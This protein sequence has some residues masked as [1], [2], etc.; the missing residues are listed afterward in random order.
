MGR[1]LGPDDGAGPGFERGAPPRRSA[2]EDPST[3]APR[4]ASLAT[5]GPTGMRGRPL[6][7][8]EAGWVLRYAGVRARRA[9][10]AAPRLCHA[11]AA[12]SKRMFAQAPLVSPNA[13]SA[14][15][16]QGS[17]EPRRGTGASRP[18]GVGAERVPPGSPRPRGLGPGLSR[19][20]V[21]GPLAQP[22][23]SGRA[24]MEACGRT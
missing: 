15:R 20:C 14:P 23:S 16:P 12:T 7:L 21:D 5:V 11:S 1:G 17:V 3:A 19:G 8:V 2:G 9:P 24:P 4:A 10:R 13:P 6:A 22:G 18:V